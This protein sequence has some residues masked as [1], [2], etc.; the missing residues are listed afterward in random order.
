MSEERLPALEEELQALRERL[1]EFERVKAEAARTETLLAGR[2][3][4]LER[5][6]AGAPLEETLLLLVQVAEQVEP[7]MTASV[8]LLDRDSGRLHHGAAPSLPDFFNEAVD[9]ILAG[10]AAGSCG[11]AAHAGQR[12]VVEDTRTHP[13]WSGYR[14]LAERAG[15]RAC[16]SEP[17]LSPAGEVLGTFAVYH[18]QPRQPHDGEV[19]LIHSFAQLA[20]LAIERTALDLSLNSAKFEL[21]SRVRQRTQELSE[22]NVKLKQE[23]AER[24]RA[25]ARFR[26][27]LE[28]APD[29]MVI[30]NAEGRIVLVNEQAER[31]FGYTREELLGETLEILVPERFRQVHAEQRIAFG[32]NPHT[33]SMGAGPELFGRHKDGSEFEA[34]IS[35]SP[36]QTEEGLLV[37]SAIRD[38]TE[39]RRVE[40]T[41]EENAV[42]LLAAQK[43]QQRLLPGAA[44]IIPGYDIAGAVYPAEFAAGDYF[45]YL[46]MDDERVGVV[47]GDVSGHGLAPSLLMASTHAYMRTLAK[48][49]SELPDIL[50]L[51]NSSLV[52][53]TEDD[54]FVTMLFACLNPRTRTFV[55]ANAGHPTGY[56]IDSPGQ[57]K[58]LLKSEAMPLGIMSENEFPVAD[59]IALDPGDL[60]LLLTDGILEAL[61]PEGTFFGAERVLDVVRQHRQRTAAE[62]TEALRDAVRRFTGRERLV[63]DVT[64]V[65]IKVEPAVVPAP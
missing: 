23:I 27:L 35:L 43:I 22:A 60:V 6:A 5:L 55:Y 14:E 54:R 10:P 16:W 9:G 19:E 47:V 21:E 7:D 49:Q 34:E 59:P 61:S 30:V 45:D 46:P 38:V 18:R 37:S 40:R 41:L 13:Y 25:E 65:V 57:I 31:L 58:A 29:A 28:S 52:A 53:E 48:M 8:L 32:G 36:I 44:P 24:E 56:V 51:V 20:A 42:Q 17:I 15:V 1:A 64:A 62:I 26:K 33:R 12:V 39:R 4:V 3:R 50:A 2:N 63:D 11:T